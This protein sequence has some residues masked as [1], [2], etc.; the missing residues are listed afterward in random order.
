MG[1]WGSSNAPSESVAAFKA[2]AESAAWSVTAALAMG[3]CWGSWTTPCTVAK[4]VANAGMEAAS[5]RT[6]AMRDEIRMGPTSGN[7]GKGRDSFADARV[8][9]IMSGALRGFVEGRPDLRETDDLKFISIC[10]A[11]E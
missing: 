9:R 2:N 11:G 4:T 7:F 10:S 3:R 6:R 8:A 1:V 5:R